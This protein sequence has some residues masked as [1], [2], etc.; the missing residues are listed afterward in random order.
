MD[1]LTRAVRVNLR[2]FL[3][4]LKKGT[5]ASA[6]DMQ[7]NMGEIIARVRKRETEW[8]EPFD[9][10][11]CQACWVQPKSAPRNGV[12]MYLHG[13][14]YVAGDLNYAM[15]F[16]SVLAAEARRRV[17]CT[18]YRLAPEH[19]FSAALDDAVSTYK[20]LLDEGYDSREIVVVGESAG[21]GLVFSLVLRLRELDLPLPAGI[22]PISPWV[23]L[24]MSG[25]SHVKNR[26]VD[27]SLTPAMMEL[28]ADAYAGDDRKNPII[29][30]LFADLTGLPPCWMYVGGDEMLLSD[31]VNM[32]IL[33][34]SYGVPCRLHVEPK[35]WHSY[36]L[37]G[38]RPAQRAVAEISKFIED[39]T[40]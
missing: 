34:H 19:P 13:G 26:D 33:L 40:I 21:G 12:I 16:G 35:M 3:P 5:I 38:V 39:V 6:R 23:D 2:V 36:V 30:S 22:V 37:Y 9:L 31:S 4:L 24:T 15:S 1:L 7:Q 29:S 25:E 20:Y 17:I 27:I 32:A 11:N 8:F 18:D 28:Y 10:P 14:G